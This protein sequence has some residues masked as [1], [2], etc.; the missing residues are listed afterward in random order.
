MPE[1]VPIELNQDVAPEDDYW[2]IQLHIPVKY[3][4]H[5]KRA[6]LIPESE[7]LNSIE[8]SHRSVLFQAFDKEGLR[9][10][11]LK[12]LKVH[13]SASF[14]MQPCRLVWDAILKPLKTMLDQFVSGRDG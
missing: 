8:K 7:R 3:Q 14:R 6:L 11:P 5:G 10:S 9:V 1:E 4:N 2:K 13:P 12:P